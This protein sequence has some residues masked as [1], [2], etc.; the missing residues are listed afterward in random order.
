MVKLMK[1]CSSQLPAASQPSGRQ[2]ILGVDPGLRV[3]G[4]G[5]I[6]IAEGTS[7]TLCEAGVI[8]APADTDLPARVGA[9]FEGMRE[10]L[11]SFHPAAVALEEIFSHYQR[12]RTAILM[13]HARGVICL[14]AEQAGVP[15]VAYAP[16]QVK[17]LLTGSGR[18]SK[19][20]IQRAIQRELSLVQ[21]PEPS[22]VADAL[23]LALCHAYLLRK[24]Q[25]IA[26]AQ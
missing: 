17:R 26:A 8:R 7:P 25:F 13:G 11:E 15:V 2:R 18:A 16:T 6:E 14:A 10:I 24:R 12:P 19:A 23:A 9:I 4:Y 5:V 1:R 22:D 3:T 21:P 20:Q